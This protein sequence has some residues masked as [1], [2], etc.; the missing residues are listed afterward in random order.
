MRPKPVHKVRPE[1]LGMGQNDANALQPNLMFWQ[2]S[3]LHHNRRH[4]QRLG[5]IHV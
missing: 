4:H 3:A 2:W 5:G 1:V